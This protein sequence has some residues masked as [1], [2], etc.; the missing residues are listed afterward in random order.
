MSDFSSSDD[1]DKLIAWSIFLK[2]HG[3]F[4][5]IYKTIFLDALACFM[6]KKRG[7]NVTKFALL[8]IYNYKLIYFY[9]KYAVIIL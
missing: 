4:S 2:R 7:R 1:D 3:L 9:N 6:R 8:H 5:L